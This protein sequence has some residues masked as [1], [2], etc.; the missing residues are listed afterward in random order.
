LKKSIA[1]FKE[2]IASE[3]YWRSAFR[4][5]LLFV[6]VW[7]II[8][9]IGKYSFSIEVFTNKIIDTGLLYR[10]INSRLVGG[11]LYGVLVAFPFQRRKILEQKHK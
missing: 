8:E 3:S 5:G 1:L 9:F 6:I 11:L 2:I 7:T 10:Y 4:L